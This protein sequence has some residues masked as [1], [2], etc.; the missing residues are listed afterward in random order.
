MKKYLVLDIGGSSIKYA[1]MNESAEFLSKGSVKTPLDCIE[2]LVEIIGQIYDDYKFEIEGMAISMP[3]VL[4]S[5]TGYAY[6]GGW[7]KY[8]SGQNIIEVLKKRCNTV[9]AIENDAKCAA[10]AELGFGSLKGCK[11]AAVIVLGTGVG[12]GIIIDGKVHKGSHSFAGE[13]SFMRMNC[14]EIDAMNHV[15]GL[16]NGAPALAETVANIKG[17]PVEGHSFAGEF[18]FMRM[19]CNEIDAMNHVWGLKNGA[20]ALAETV[21]NIKGIPV[22]EVNGLFIFELANSGDA[23]ILTV[24]DEFTRW[25]AMQIIDIQCLIDPELVA[26]GGGI[27]A[28]PLLIELIQKHLDSMEENFGFYKPSVRVVPCEFRNDANLIGALYSFLTKNN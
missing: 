5:D 27:S 16:K 24:L 2:S 1:M 22:E 28:Q 11:D 26:I 14:N 23:K 12:G 18:S 3:G 10:S 20:P 15:W 6:S 4:D 13:F 9:I 21:A 19:N 8:N 25:I 7:L 17:I